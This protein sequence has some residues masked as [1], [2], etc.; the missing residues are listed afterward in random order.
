MEWQ[1]H[2]KEVT[3]DTANM[4]L[5]E[6]ITAYVTLKENL[7]SPATIRGYENIRKNKLDTLTNKKLSRITKNDIQSEIN[8]ES[9]NSSPKTVRNIYGLLRTV[10]NE[11]RPDFNVKITLPQKK[12]FTGQSLT[13]EQIGKLLEA[14]QGDDAEIPI[15]LALWLG[16][17]RSEIIGLKW[18][19]I[20]L[21]SHT[22]NVCAALVPD[23]DNKFVLKGTKTESSNRTL[24]IPDYIYD[25]LKIVPHKTEFVA[26]LAGDTIRK[27]LQRFCHSAGIPEIRLHDLRHTMASVGL[28][29]NISDKYMMER[30]GWSSA[31]T[32]KSIYQH[33]VKDGQDAADTTINKYFESLIKK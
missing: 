33:T 7:L 28:L 12:K 8:K 30:G 11:Y 17:R 6:S 25:K 2:Y 1:E 21:E 9:E 29:L 18:D 13:G 5:D 10:M 16:L 20:N 4:T 32:M 3:N 22:L 23:K 26:T 24:C 15:L 14:I 31:G 27:R 19:C